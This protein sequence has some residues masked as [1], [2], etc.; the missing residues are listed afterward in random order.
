MHE[1]L[2]TKCNFLLLNK[3]LQLVIFVKY[4]FQHSSDTVAEEYSLKYRIGRYGVYN[5]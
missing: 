2:F 1:N 4:N 5:S 3:N